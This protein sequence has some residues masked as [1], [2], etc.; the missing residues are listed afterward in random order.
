GAPKVRNF[1]VQRTVTL[2][3]TSLQGRKHISAFVIYNVFPVG[4][5]RAREVKRKSTNSLAH[6][7]RAVRIRGV[8]KVVDALDWM[9]LTMARVWAQDDSQAKSLAGK[10]NQEL[11]AVAKQATHNV[12]ASVR[13]T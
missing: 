3:R 1:N 11:V 7:M 4:L 8:E 2:R 10:S 6:K 12:A 13:L 9:P 5:V